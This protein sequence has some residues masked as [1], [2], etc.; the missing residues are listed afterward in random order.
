MATSVFGS[1]PKGLVKFEE[2]SSEDRDDFRLSEHVG[3]V[4]QFIVA[5]PEQV[6]T[7][8]Y[9][10][11]T[12]IR[13]EVKLND[14]GAIKTY[15]NVLIFNAAPV[16]QLKGLTGQAPIAAIVQYESKTGTVAPK[17]DT[18][19]DEQVAEFERLLAA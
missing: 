16:S 6:S 3:K 12:A 4:A 14:G 19:T 13:C 7:G 18:P 10:E 5:G 15:T 11:K 1:A 9:G 2:A 17:L 8:K